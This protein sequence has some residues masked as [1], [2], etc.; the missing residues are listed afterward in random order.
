[1]TTRPGVRVIYEHKGGWICYQVGRQI[2]FVAHPDH[3]LTALA[4][5]RL[6]I[7]ESFDALTELKGR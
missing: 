4:Q 7:G 2:A 3:E 1:M 6:A 5:F